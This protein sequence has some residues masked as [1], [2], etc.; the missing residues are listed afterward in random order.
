MELLTIP[1]SNGMGIFCIKKNTYRQDRFERLRD[2]C[3][4]LGQL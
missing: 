4:K 1:T 3:G 2:R